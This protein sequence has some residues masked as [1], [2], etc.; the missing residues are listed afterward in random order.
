[1]PVET[2]TITVD[3]PRVSFIKRDSQGQVYELSKGFNQILLEFL[4]V[5]PNTAS[6]PSIVSTLGSFPDGNTSRS[7]D[8]M[9]KGDFRNKDKTQ[10][11]EALHSLLKQGSFTLDNEIFTVLL[12]CVKNAVTINDKMDWINRGI[13]KSIVLVCCYRIVCVNYF[14]VI[15]QCDKLINDIPVQICRHLIEN[16]QVGSRVMYNLLLKQLEADV[17][18]E[19]LSQALASLISTEPFKTVRISNNLL[20]YMQTVI[21]INSKLLLDVCSRTW[22]L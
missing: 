17:L 7:V 8:M 16:N 3:F 1:M 6:Y 14:K 11:L 5:V 20:H 10:L 15:A 18:R 13:L 12:D 2:L 19:S 9:S 4:G 22:R 21:F